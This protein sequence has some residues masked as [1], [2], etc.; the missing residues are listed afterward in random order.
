VLTFNQVLFFDASLPQ[1]VWA[2]LTVKTA[3]AA[4]AAIT[5]SI[6]GAAVTDIPSMNDI[7]HRSS[8]GKFK[9]RTQEVLNSAPEVVDTVSHWASMVLNG[10]GFN[11][12]AAEVMTSG[13]SQDSFA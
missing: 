12:F 4:L 7:F 10:G 1:F 5:F 2:P 3:E 11:W 13:W 8:N 9:V 6:K